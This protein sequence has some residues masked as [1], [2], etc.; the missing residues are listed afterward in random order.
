MLRVPGRRTRRRGWW[1]PVV[2]GKR[3]TRIYIPSNS[4]NFW[5]GMIPEKVLEGWGFSPASPKVYHY[6]RDHDS[7][8]RR[9]GF[10]FGEM[11]QG[12]DDHPQNCKA[13]MKKLL[14]EKERAAKVI[15][16]KRNTILLLEI[17]SRG[18]NWRFLQG[19]SVLIITSAPWMMTAACYMSRW[20]HERNQ[21]WVGR[22]DLEPGNWM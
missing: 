11:E 5:C 17:R 8:C 19:L 21:N 14:K 22:Y 7:L 2:H 10:F 6:F 20:K 1:Y 3:E 9:I 12:K 13:C 4:F 15:P 16:W 18:S